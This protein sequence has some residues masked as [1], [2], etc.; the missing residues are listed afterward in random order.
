M[1]VDA[2]RPVSVDATQF[3]IGDDVIVEV[4]AT[5]VDGAYG[6]A[7]QVGNGASSADIPLA[8]AI[9]ARHVPPTIDPSRY[10]IDRPG[11]LYFG[12]AGGCLQVLAPKNIGKTLGPDQVPRLVGLR[13][14]EVRA[15]VPE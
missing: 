1:S 7:A 10:Y 3:R 5:I 9:S 12:L 4:R 6:L 2:T 11:T 13:P 14:A 15:V 8:S